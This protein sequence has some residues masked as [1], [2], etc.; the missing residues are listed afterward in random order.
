MLGYREGQQ[1]RRGGLDVVISLTEDQ[2]AALDTDAAGLAEALD[3][4]LVG[5]AALRTGTDPRVAGDASMKDH[6]VTAG[7]TW[8][9]WL[10]QDT[11][12]LLTRLDG[13]RAA[14]IRAHA[15]HGGT[16][17]QLAAAMGVTR[18]T[19][20]SRRNDLT[21]VEP[22]PA[23][24]WATGSYG[25]VDH[26]GA[27]V[28][29]AMRSWSVPWHGYTPVDITPQEL[30][31]EQGLAAVEDWAEP[32][33]DPS[34]VPDWFDRQAAALIPFDLDDR[35]WPLNPTGRTG[36]TGR[37]LG[38]WGENA[39]ADPIVVAG[40]AADRHVLLIKR[41]DRGV[42]AI[43]GGMVDPGETAPA[44]LVRE[45]REE[46][47]VDLGEVTPAILTRTYVDDWR[48]TDHAWVC[49]TVAL[50]QVPE[51]L[52]ATAGDDA[53][54]AAW[55]PFADLDQLTTA[56]EGQGRQLYEAHRPLLTA[57]LQRLN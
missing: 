33:A 27:R 10:L 15:A 6:P 28:P 22:G 47:S 31:A 1:A 45:L 54:D 38:K 29:E 9:E 55:V 35:H 39:A 42:W 5:I 11:C 57:A 53:A 41:S 37:N 7:Q 44:T 51:Q 56:L 25:P 17:G 26:P 32:Y 46:T 24:L 2:A 19:A 34:E 49:S 18:A 23:E 36:R 50:Y 4:V 20:Q 13:L 14:A 8:D 48:N 43:P 12:A 30:R 52:A 40:T 21:R 3:T 16:Y